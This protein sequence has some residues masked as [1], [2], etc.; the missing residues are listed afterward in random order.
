MVLPVPLQNSAAERDRTPRRAQ[1]EHPDESRRMSAATTV[2]PAEL[3]ER[4]RAAEGHEQPSSPRD[5]SPKRR[6]EVADDSRSKASRATSSASA[7]QTIRQEQEAAAN[8]PAPTSGDE[9]HVDVLVHEV[10]GD[11][12]DGWRCVDGGFELD[13]MLYTAYRK[14]EVNP[15]QLNID[16]Q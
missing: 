16:E 12:P 14:G 3:P 5:R 10:V 1:Q 2:E 6:S 13:D 9:L 8:T 15:R 11:L 4:G 7:V